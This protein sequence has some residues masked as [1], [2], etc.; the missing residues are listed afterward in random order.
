M[1]LAACLPAHPSWCISAL[2]GE[3]P[4]LPTIRV[5][6]TH[7]IHRGVP[8]TRAQLPENKPSARNNNNICGA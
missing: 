3:D 1:Q 4:L 8:V 2:Q 6:P 7:C 5:L